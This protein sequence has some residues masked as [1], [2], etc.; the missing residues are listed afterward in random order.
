MKPGSQSETY[1]FITYLPPG[2][3]GLIGVKKRNT[4]LL[5]AFSI[6]SKV[7]NVCLI[8]SAAVEI[9]RNN[10]DPNNDPGK[11]IGEIFSWLLGI[12]FTLYFS[13]C[14]RSFKREVAQEQI[15]EDHQPEDLEAAN[16]SAEA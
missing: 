6:F 12:C 2:I 11:L 13:L 15:Q 5:G 10:P 8:V 16:A 7:V 4:C 9:S 14:M 1:L 3:L